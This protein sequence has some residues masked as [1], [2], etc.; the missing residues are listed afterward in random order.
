M[1]ESKRRDRHY[2]E[3]V[4]RCWAALPETGPDTGALPAEI[5]KSWQRCT[6]LGLEKA[7]AGQNVA[8]V[9]ASKSSEGFQTF[10][11]RAGGQ[12]VI[13]SCLLYTSDAA[14]D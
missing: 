11:I 4:K 10:R 3:Q 2:F 13:F 6:A 1:T 14:D 7:Q 9:M 5:L 12:D 8:A